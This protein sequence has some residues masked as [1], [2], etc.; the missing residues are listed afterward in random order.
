MYVYKFDIQLNNLPKFAEKSFST[1]L[2]LFDNVIKN[3]SVPI[4]CIPKLSTNILVF[5][6]IYNKKN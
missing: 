5:N 6:D 3:K 4:N 2:T 1:P